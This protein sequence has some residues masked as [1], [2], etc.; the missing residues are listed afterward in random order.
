MDA[1]Y[2][3]TGVEIWEQTGGAVTHFVAGLGTSGTFTGTGRRL[4]DFRP[5][6]QLVSVEPDA[7]FHGLEGLKHMDTAIR[8]GLYDPGLADRTLQVSTEAAHTLA[9]RL[10]R[11]EGWLVGISAA[12]ALVVARQV[13]Q[14]QADLGRP[15]CIVTILAD[16]AHKYLSESFWQ[17]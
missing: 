1:H 4:R 11:E 14:E 2:E 12:A 5:Q 3:T 9:R 7:P 6:V 13:A 10:A 16:S 15:A 17:S 8:P